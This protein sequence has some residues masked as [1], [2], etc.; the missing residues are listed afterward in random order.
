MV[1]LVGLLLLLI[2]CSPEQQ[3]A[4]DQINGTRREAG[5]TELLPSPHAMEK[6][7]AWA[8]AAGGRMD[9]TPE[10]YIPVTPGPSRHDLG[11]QRETRRS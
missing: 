8:T 1:A 10:G 9:C 7:Q 6:A 5:L 2:G 3:A 4:L 11:A